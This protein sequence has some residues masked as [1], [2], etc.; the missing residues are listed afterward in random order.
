MRGRTLGWRAAAVAAAALL[1]TAAPASAD[2]HVA[3]GESDAESIVLLHAHYPGY[4]WDHTDLTVAVL[5][6]PNV[7]P[8]NVAAIRDAIATWSDVL[9]EQFPTVSLTDVTDK[10]QTPQRADIVVHYVPHAGGIVWG[11]FAQCGD[12]RCNNILVRSDVPDLIDVACPTTIR[13]GSTGSRSTSW[14]TPSASATPS[15]ST[16]PST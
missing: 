10:A 8:A 7:D 6:A 9:A 11:G 16:R 2:E 14:A 3:F 4:S 13:C 12:H 1:F 5:S 15:R